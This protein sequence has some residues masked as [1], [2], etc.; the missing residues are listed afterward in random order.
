MENNEKESE[1]RISWLNHS[2]NDLKREM[3]SSA[4]GMKEWRGGE[5]NDIESERQG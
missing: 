2:T 4:A 1:L 5:K 3:V